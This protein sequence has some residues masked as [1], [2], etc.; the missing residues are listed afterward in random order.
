MLWGDILWA[1]W[2]GERHAQ[3]LLNMRHA[4]FRQTDRA[5]FFIYLVI[6]WVERL[7]N[8]RHADV[9]LCVLMRRTGD[10]QRRAGFI[11]EDVIYLIDNGIV[12]SALHT[13]LPAHGDVIAQIVKTKL[14]V[15]AV[16]DISE[17]SLRAAY[18][19]QQVGLL[20]Q[21]VLVWIVDV[22]HLVAIS[23]GG[24]LQHAHA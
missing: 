3:H 15:G 4:N 8:L 13:A 1:L 24:H 17:V 9:I 2:I 7:G 21:G 5:F 23:A 12:M 6:F 19:A 18:W 22:S 10:N 14:G 16:G 20:A 11:N